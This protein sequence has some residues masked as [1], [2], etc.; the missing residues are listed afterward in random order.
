MHAGPGNPYELRSAAER[1]LGRGDRV[2][3]LPRRVPADAVHVRPDPVKPGQNDVLV[4]PG[5]HREADAG[6]L[7]HPLQARPRPRATARCRR[8]SRSTSTTARGS[9]PPATTAP[10]PFFAA[11]EEKTICAVPP[12]LR[13]ADQG[14]RPVAA[15]LHDP[16]RASRRPTSSTSPTTSTSS[17]RPRRPPARHQAGRTR[18]G[19]TCGRRATRCSTSSAG[20]GAD[21]DVHLAAAGVRRLRPLRQGDPRPGRAGRHARAPTGSSR[22]RASA[23]ADRRTSRAA[24]SIG[25][26]GHLHPGGLTNDIDLVRNG[27][28]TPH[29]HGRGRLLGPRR[30]DA[31]RRTADIV[32]L[33]DEGHRAPAMG[34]ARRARRHAAQQRHATTRRSSRRTRTWASPSRCIAPDQ[35]DGTPTAPG[36]DP[37]APG[38]RLRHLGRTATPVAC[39][40]PRR[41]LCDKGIATHGTSPRTTT[42]AARRGT[43]LTVKRRRP[44]ERVD[45]AAFLYA[46]GRPV[47][48]QHDRHPHREARPEGARSRTS[49]AASTC[50]TRSLRAP[51]RARV[52]RAR[53]S[54][55]RTARR[56]PGALVDFD[57]GELG[58]RHPRDHRGQERVTWDLDLH[59]ATSRARSSRTTAASIRSC[60]ARVE[61]APVIPAGSDRGTSPSEDLPVDVLPCS[62]GEFI[63]PPPTAR[64]AHDHGA[65]RSARP[66]GGGAGSA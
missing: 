57:S 50:T 61:V 59:A 26:G 66:S 52:R 34:R 49:T 12:R 37:F 64:A 15:P 24:R 40:P 25:I 65:R 44:T 23:R 16:Q 21:G 11:G 8:S 51:T 45:I 63:P 42:S 36:V 35:P 55:S 14:D 43:T 53:R 32:G 7:H 38:V 17:R 3:P 29:L 39:W 19:S 47:D 48:D 46:P 10:G 1:G 22:S 18:S 28:A 31:A 56:A 9:T 33:L 6:R 2:R 60:A 30:L 13:H 20:F 27:E 41:R 54:R 62:N 4:T 58:Y 5:D